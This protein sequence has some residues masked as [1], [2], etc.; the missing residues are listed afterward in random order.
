MV[1]FK[2]DRWLVRRLPRKGEEPQGQDDRNQR[3]SR[4]AGRGPPWQ[5]PPLDGALNGRRQITSLAWKE[6]EENMASLWKLAIVRSQNKAFLLA[7]SHGKHPW[8]L[9]SHRTRP[10]EREG[11]NPALI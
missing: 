9:L 3:R 7:C 4:R 8:G 1:E 2:K 5:R 10:R 11:G 6:A